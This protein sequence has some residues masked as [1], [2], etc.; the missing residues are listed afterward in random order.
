[1]PTTSDN[2]QAPQARLLP[3]GTMLCHGKYRIVRHLGSGGFGNTY[4]AVD[5]SFNAKV[6]IKELFIKGTCGRA[7]DSREVSISLEENQRTFEQQKRKFRKEA[8]RLHDLH[9]PHIVHV[10]DLF[11]DC[12]TSYY[13]MDYVDGEN[14]SERLKRTG[15]P[16]GE[17]EVMEQI[18]PQ[19]LDALDTV[20]AQGIWHLDIKPGNIL[21]DGKGGVVLIDFGA[22]KQLHTADGQTQSTSALTCT[23]GY[24]PTEQM[25]GNLEKFGPWTDLYSLGATLYHLLTLQRPPLPSSISEDPDDALTFPK[26]CGP[27]TVKLVKWLMQPMRTMRP[28]SVE[29]VRQFLKDASEL[30]AKPKPQPQPQP[31]PQPQPQPQP[32]PKPNDDADT[33]KIKEE[34]LPPNPK[35]KPNPKPNPKPKPERRMPPIPSPKPNGRWLKRMALGVVAV[36]IL[37]SVGLGVRKCVD[38]DPAPMPEP[39]DSDSVLFVMKKVTDLPVSVTEGPKNMHHY[40]F[41]GELVDSVGALPD[42]PGVAKFEATDGVPA[43]TY[44]G[45]F[46]RGLCHDATGKANLTFSTGDKYVGTFD[47]GYYATGRYTLKDGSYFSG[48]FK[49]GQPYNGR[50]FNSD[51]SLSAN[52]RHGIEKE[53]K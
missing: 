39:S 18:V 32:Q 1:M 24:A 10:H 44:R 5:T 6:A 41:T 2:H 4:E 37:A 27:V 21:T 25:D 30:A 40:L 16:V 26:G 19:L 49:N 29:D 11:D 8:Q 51:G 13:V 17:K 20:H 34:N 7:A 45:R 33:I 23:P 47:H 48:T 12:G 3:V 14:L 53:G 50:W 38:P 28:Q 52:V 43:A 15:K 9:N 31:K 42:G 22:S 36:G 35:P 46:E